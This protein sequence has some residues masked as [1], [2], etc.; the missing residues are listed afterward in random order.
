M[1]RETCASIEHQA[2][3]EL[4]NA[5]CDVCNKAKTQRKPKRKGQLYLGPK[6]L[7]FGDQVTGDI[8]TK[9]KRN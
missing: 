9:N 3:H 1:L 8:S 6:P 4:Q 2:T 7:A 5:F